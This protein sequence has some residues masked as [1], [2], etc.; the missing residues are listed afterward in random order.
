MWQKTSKKI[1]A[2][3][4]FYLSTLLTYGNITEN[5]FGPLLFSC[6][7]IGRPVPATKLLTA[8]C[9]PLKLPQFGG[10]F[11]RR[12][13]GRAA[14]EIV[15]QIGRGPFSRVVIGPGPGRA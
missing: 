9:S 1:I 4:D 12:L 5:Y 6:R 3:D 8:N 11:R 2:R 15:A 7:N 14:G 13:D 10:Q